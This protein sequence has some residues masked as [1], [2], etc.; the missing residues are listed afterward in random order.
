MVRENRIYNSYL[1][2]Y[3]DGAINRFDHEDD[4]GRFKITYRNGK[5]YKTYMKEGK[6]IEDVWIDEINE[7]DVLDIPI[8]M[9]N[10]D[11]EPPNS[12]K[13]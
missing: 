9:K 13:K 6:P 4:Q 5:E 1:I 3:A 10:I 12:R 2:P 11:N 7:L 8:I